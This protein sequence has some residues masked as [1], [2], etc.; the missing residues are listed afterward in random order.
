[1][2]VFP[3]QTQTT[4]GQNTIFRYQFQNLYSGM[5][6]RKKNSSLVAFISVFLIII[7]GGLITY[8]FA[9]NKVSDSTDF[10]SLVEQFTFPINTYIK[11]FSI[12]FGSLTLFFI[13]FAL[14]STH[15]N[16]KTAAKFG[17]Y[18]M[19]ILDLLLLLFNFSF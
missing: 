5:V 11:Y 10:S 17:F 2:Y 3:R 12:L 8:W 13:S 1:M 14:I 15:K 18:L 7:L 6:I 19:I 16:V 4:F 9:D